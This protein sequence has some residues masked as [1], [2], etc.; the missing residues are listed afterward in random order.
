MTSPG[1]GVAFS[2][3]SGLQ[4]TSRKR[5]QGQC[6]DAIGSSSKLTVKET[7]KNTSLSFGRRLG[8]E[9]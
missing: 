2:G 8:V 7:I 3:A 6:D 9:S 5:V 4:R 1:I